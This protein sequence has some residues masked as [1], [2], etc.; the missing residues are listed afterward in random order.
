[1]DS[2]RPEL[3]HLPKLLEKIFK[4]E[5]SLAHLL[6]HPRG[7]VGADRLGG[8]LDQAD[9]V[10]HAED[11]GG[12][13]LGVE[14]LELVEFFAHARELDGLAGDRPQAERRAAAGVAVQF[15]QDRTGDIQGLVEMG[16]HVHRFLS[17]SGVQHQQRLLRLDQ[18]AQPHQFLDQRLVYLQPAGGVENQGVAQVRP[19]EFKGPARDAQD[20]LLPLLDEDR[21]AHL[22]AQ[23][24]QLFHRRRPVNIRR[25]E[26]RRPALLQ[27]PPAEL[28]AR[29]RLARAV[30]PNH[31]DA[32]RVAAQ[33]HARVGRTQQVHK[34]VVDDLNDLLPGLDALDHL[35]RRST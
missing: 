3:L 13:A 34:L 14:G 26:Q 29:C 5:L 12:H 6:L 21:H 30:Q 28:A 7:L 22:L 27:Q 25:H 1:M 2:Q 20:V 23:S 16:R 18:V 17:G 10:A 33:L 8:L 4:G 24:R 32:T 35:L 15:G 9:D 31:Q 19:R 11:A